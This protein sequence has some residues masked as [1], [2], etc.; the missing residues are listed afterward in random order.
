MPSK[1]GDR[2]FDLKDPEQKREYYRLYRRQYT[3]DKPDVVKKH[4]DKQNEKN[5]VRRE[6]DPEYKTKMKDMRD[7]YRQNNIEKLRESS[8]RRAFI[9][10][11]YNEEHREKQKKKNLERYH[12][13]S[14]EE[15]KA[16]SERNKYKY[17]EKKEQYQ[18]NQKVYQEGKNKGQVY[19][20]LE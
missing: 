12:N 18:R 11:T 17:A 10:Y 4:A 2:E 20:S 5:K 15:K 8:R 3:K 1:I 7:T 6:T 14:P 19:F 9:K 16:L 13:K